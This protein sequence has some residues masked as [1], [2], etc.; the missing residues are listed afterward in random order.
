VLDHLRHHDLG[1]L[2]DNVRD[3]F[4][5][6][7][8]RVDDDQAW[9]YLHQRGR[10][11]PHR[12]LHSTVRG[13]RRGGRRT[14]RGRPDHR[15]EHDRHHRPRKLRY[16]Q[17]GTFRGVVFG[18]AI[19]ATFATFVGLGVLDMLT[20][21]FSGITSEISSDAPVACPRS[22]T[23]LASTSACCGSSGSSCSR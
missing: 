14:R 7:Q 1:P 2:T 19:G 16:Q 4:A 18:I 13:G 15:R 10:L 17:A 8:V 3:L 6:L 22:S 20:G 5:R 11:A 21:L 9:T 12:A 23:W